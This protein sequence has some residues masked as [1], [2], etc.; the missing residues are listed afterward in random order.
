MKGELPKEFIIPNA[1]NIPV[2]NQENKSNCTSHA[3]ATM[4][5]Y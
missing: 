3:F 4:W 2:N 5:E 1:Y